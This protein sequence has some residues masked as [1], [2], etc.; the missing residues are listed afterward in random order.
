MIAALLTSAW[1]LLYAGTV[2]TAVARAF[3]R[4]ERARTSSSS[5]SCLLLRP[6]AGDEPGLEARLLATGGASLVV[7]AVGDAQDA[8]Y[9]VASRAAAA[10]RRRGIDASVVQTHATGLN[11]K[12]A[13]LARAVATSHAR[14]VVVADSDVALRDGDLARLR[15]ALADGTV[16]AAW[17]PPVER[18]EVVTLGD[19]A[20]RAVLDAS[21]HAFPLLGAID[22]SGLVGK[23][24]AIRRDA[25]DAIGGFAPLVGVIGEDMELAR[26]LRAHGYRS[27]MVRGLVARSMASARPLRDVL[28]RYTR[29]LVVIRMQRPGLLLSYPTLLAPAP[30]LFLALALAGDRTVLVLALLFR[31]LVSCVARRLAG[32]P[33]A[34][35]R[36]AAQGLLADLTLLAACGAALS[37]REVR[38]RGR[39]LRVSRRQEAREETL[40]QVPDDA[41]AAGVD[42][43][44]LI[45]ESTALETPVDSGEL[46]LDPQLLEGDAA[47]DVALGGERLAEGEPEIG[48]LGGAE[49]V[50][51]ADRHDD[52]ASRDAR[53]LRR[54]GTEREGAERRALAALG[55]DPQGAPCAIEQARGMADGSGA[56]GRVVEVDAERA[57]AAKE[58]QA[59]QVRRVHHRIAVAGEQELAGV[60]RD[61]RIPPRRMIGDE[62]GRRPR[63]DRARLLEAGDEH[64]SERPLDACARVAGEPRIEPAALGGRNHEVGP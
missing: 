7:F 55:E 24:F 46:T 2:S 9:P 3:R 5:A 20:S 22:E 53:D 37:S 26:R 52:R 30:L 50:A 35:L 39:T 17:A 62:D 40:G 31:L 21:L 6:L 8:A 59:P 28:A 61:Q 45:G 49:D 32:L 23:L 12:A 29:W 33:F 13:Q 36:A 58:R 10:L 57:D 41:R 1:T 47:R 34:P 42:H 56:V 63:D 19:Q 43:G 18:G 44:E 11:H 38:W 15:E 54:A 60:E 64:A 27:V 51:Q 4:P 16:M 48:L 14:T 25:L